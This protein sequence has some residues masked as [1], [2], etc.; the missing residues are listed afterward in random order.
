MKFINV[1]YKNFLKKKEGQKVIH[2]GAAT[3]WNYYLKAFPDID[4]EVL[5]DTLFIVDNSPAKQGTYLTIKERKYEIK[6]PD[7]LRELENGIILLTASIAYQESICR[8]LLEMNLPDSV[9]CYSLPLMSYEQKELDNACVSS[10]FKQHCTRI[11]VPKIHCFWFS[12]EEKPD[13][14]KRCLDS[15]H[16]VCQEFEI[17]E[18]NTHNYD[19]TKNRY[20]QEAFEHRKWAFVS[21][22]ARLDVVYHHGGI[23]MDMDVE[24]YK[25][26]IT[27]LNADRFFCRQEDGF[28]EL[29]SG[30]GAKAGDELIGRML[31]TYAD[32]RLMRKDGSMDM[33]C[34]PEWLSDVLNE[35]GLGRMHDSQ[36]I[37]DTLILS[38]DYIT[39]SETSDALER[40]KLGVHWHNGGWLDEK[41]RQ[42]LHNNKIVKD[43]L[44]SQ[45]FI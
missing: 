27:L 15:W 7:C 34:Q 18:W 13:I 11:N 32:R 6:S 5:S 24:L 10:Y 22:Y 40:A 16:R 35:Y 26:P 9:E 12:G 43:I 4:E 17:I 1:S 36:V 14:Y 8:Q 28:I 25:S 37:N 31:D 23:Y 45:F 42:L 2:F 44:L 30:F 41:T 29:G 3:I 20:M 19:V 39:C 38:N 21:D 33:T